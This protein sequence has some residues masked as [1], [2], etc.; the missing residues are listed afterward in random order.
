MPEEDNI[1][2]DLSKRLEE[3][4]PKARVIRDAAGLDTWIKE[5]KAAGEDSRAIEGAKAYLEE[6]LF[7]KNIT[8]V[9]QNGSLTF[10]NEFDRQIPVNDPLILN[11]PHLDLHATAGSRTWAFKPDSK[12]PQPALAADESGQT[13]PVS[14]VSQTR[15]VPVEPVG[16]NA[17]P[18]SPASPTPVAAADSARPEMTVNTDTDAHSGDEPGTIKPEGFL[19]KNAMGIAAGVLA[20]VIGSALGGGL[21]GL[22]LAALAFVAVSAMTGGVA[23][24]W[25]GMKKDASPD[26]GPTVQTSLANSPAIQQAQD[27]AEAARNAKPTGSKDSDELE[28]NIR[29]AVDQRAGA[30]RIAL[31]SAN[32][33][34]SFKLGKVTVEGNEYEAHMVGRK[35]AD[36]KSATFD[37]IEYRPKD[38]DQ[39]TLVAQLPVAQTYQLEL[40]KDKQAG[41]EQL[42]VVN[43]G[44][45]RNAEGLTFSHHRRRME[46]MLERSLVDVTFVQSDPKS[47]E[48]NAN[49]GKITVER[50]GQKQTYDVI[51]S[52]KIK[53]FDKPVAGSVIAEGVKLR[54]EKGNFATKDTFEVLD[55]QG[56]L[57]L[58]QPAAYA[59]DSLPPLASNEK[60]YTTVKMQRSDIASPDNIFYHAN[61]QVQTSNSAA[62]LVHTP[63]DRAQTEPFVSA[64]LPKTLADGPD[65]PVRVAA[66]SP[67]RVHEDN[68]AMA[69]SNASPLKRAE[70]NVPLVLSTKAEGGCEIAECNIN[71][72][73]VT[74]NMRGIIQGKVETMTLDGTIDPAS[75]KVTFTGVTAGGRERYLKRHYTF[76][77]YSEK[78]AFLIPEEFSKG[79]MRSFIENEVNAGIDLLR[80]VAQEESIKKQIKAVEAEV[81]DAEIRAAAA[82]R[83]PS[84][85]KNQSDKQAASEPADGQ[86][87]SQLAE[88]W[89]A[90]EFAHIPVGGKDSLPIDPNKLDKDR[91]V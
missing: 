66:F 62:A 87:L 9:E 21:I 17:A 81:R 22:L 88:Q 65:Q 15:E 38:K 56:L 77:M 26:T 32:G 55:D 79:Q 23:A 4:Y 50:G 18:T 24:D 33:Q 58:K 3:R 47:P 12:M 36:G 54:D 80:E 84:D 60:T 86:K 73:H 13:I 25:L 90:G 39:E 67:T 89:K 64:D 53:D 1:A 37:R 68:L 41:K 70:R 42:Q 16:D 75:N 28:T 76:D 48:V 74:Y 7:S 5:R 8:L 35:A 30:E 82:N 59:L 10:F 20:W 29:R 57:R 31:E 91:H 78:S 71:G 44:S 6:Y 34:D 45:D 2:N 46:D 19:G 69:E 51:L 85:K 52:G 63:I 11:F 14:T 43:T 40:T 27:A 83:T 72:E 49:L 61:Q